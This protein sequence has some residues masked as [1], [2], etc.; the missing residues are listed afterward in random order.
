MLVRVIDYIHLNPVRAKIIEPEK[1][2]TFTHGS[3]S[4]FAAGN[5]PPGLSCEVI[6]NHR[7]AAD[8]PE[9]WAGYISE[10]SSRAL[11]V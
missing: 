2:K 6:L 10:L 1:L 8:T 3:L 9:T 4:N 5:R 11:D 7:E